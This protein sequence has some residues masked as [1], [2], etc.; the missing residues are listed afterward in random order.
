MLQKRLAA[1]ID[2]DISKTQ[3]GFRKTKS[4]AIPIACIRR[5]LDEAEATKKTL[6]IT[7]LDWEKAFDRIKQDK[8]M[9]ALERRDIP[10]KY[11]KANSK[12]L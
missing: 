11:L 3:L 8:L 9:E 2:E 12:Y 7:F 5:L 4:M 6:C 1:A 10:D